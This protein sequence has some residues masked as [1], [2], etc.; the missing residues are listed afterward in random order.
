MTRRWRTGV[1][2][3]VSG[4][5]SGARDIDEIEGTASSCAPRRLFFPPLPLFLGMLQA[6][7]QPSDMTAWSGV[8][9]KALASEHR[10]F[11]VPSAGRE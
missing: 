1:R 8:E 11:A 5:R 7:E 6:D 3:Q 10:T 2:C 4:R 9:P